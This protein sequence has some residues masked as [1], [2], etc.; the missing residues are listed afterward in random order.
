MSTIGNM[1]A[2][3][4]LHHQSA[5][6]PSHATHTAVAVTVHQCHELWSHIHADE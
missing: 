3:G 4:Q 2:I 6:T 5:T 1:L